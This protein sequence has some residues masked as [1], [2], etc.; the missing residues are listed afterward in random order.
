MIFSLAQ[1]NLKV[2]LKNY[3]LYFISAVLDVTIFFAFQNILFNDQIKGFL[4]QDQR[5]LMLFKGAAI[6]IVIFAA[7]FICYSSSFFIK[8]RKK[9]LGIY[10]LLGLKKKDIAALLF[11]ENIMIGSLAIISGIF[12]GGIFSK[13]FMVV[14][15]KFI[16]MNIYVKFA[17]SWI[18]VLYTAIAFGILFLTNSIYV[19]SV[20]YRFQ[21]IDL[22]KAESITENR[23]VK[24]EKSSLMLA[25]FSI[26]LFVLEALAVIGITDSATF[27]TNMPIVFLTFLTG[28]FIFFS[29]FL[30]FMGSVLKNNKKLYYRGDNLIS[31]SHFAYRIKANKKLLA[32]IAITN[33]V[34]LISISMTCSSN[35]NINEIHRTTYP[36]SYC[37][38]TSGKD[39]DCKVENLIDKYPGNAITE[40][41]EVEMC[42]LDGKLDGFDESL[43]FD[44]VYLIGESQ[45][46]KALDIK[47][48]RQNYKE[49]LSTEAILLKYGP[50]N[51]D[52]VR[53]EIVT[54]ASKKSSTPLKI[55]D[56][57]QD[58]PLNEMGIEEVLLVRDEVY[59]TYYNE[60]NAVMLKAYSVEN[61][62]DTTKLSKGIIKLMPENTDLSY[63]QAMKPVL[64]FSTMLL[65]IGILVGL[66]FLTSTGSVLYFKQLTEATDDRARYI[67]LK[68]IG[69]SKKEIKRSIK[70]QVIVIFALPI[71]IGIFH[72]IV[73]LIFLSSITDMS[74]RVPVL[75]SMA[76]YI[77]IYAFYYVLTVSTYTK[78]V[79]EN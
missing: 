35:Y 3:L 26:A 27:Y 5:F 61:A 8:K 20:M 13:L 34:A 57:K 68:K 48:L 76:A 33:A 47:G 54:I 42:K 60:E 52:N 23:C 66:V 25:V 31:I 43:N 56:R 21:L 55:I 67:V 53:G 73:A 44:T 40:S 74:I 38:V 15:L 78:I 9:E 71:I 63:T 75:I 50:K 65:F 51:L 36:F 4:E 49:F 2:N 24:N 28:T 45:Y 19:C 37:Y 59:N 1:K 10:S 69:I 22:F 62:M 58:E 7:M 11:Y 39:L 70:K 14:L 18:A 79:T 30:R 72:N 6:V 41:T 16:G 64:I 32:V 12:I 29:A 77:S 17:I 46:K